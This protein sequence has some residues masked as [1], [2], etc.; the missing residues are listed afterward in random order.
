MV[1]RRIGYMVLHSHV[2]CELCY[3]KPWGQGT[4]IPY[5]MNEHRVLGLTKCSWGAKCA[6]IRNNF[7]D[8]QTRIRELLLDAQKSW[9]DIGNPRPTQHNRLKCLGDIVYSHEA[10]AKR[11][12]EKPGLSGDGLSVRAKIMDANKRFEKL[13]HD[14]GHKHQFEDTEMDPLEE[15]A[16]MAELSGHPGETSS[17]LSVLGG[18]G[19]PFS[20]NG[21]PTTTPSPRTP[22]PTPEMH[23]TSPYRFSARSDVVKT[24]LNER[25]AA[26]LLGYAAPRS[27]QSG[28]HALA[29]RKADGNMAGNS[30]R[31]CPRSCKT[32]GRD[33]TRNAEKYLLTY[34]GVC[35][36]S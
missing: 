21:Q 7:L 11:A 15:L 36:T 14:C 32:G 28:S 13:M 3:I 22:Q 8:I 30:R 25:R 27:C 20:F 29:L 19:S 31:A 17:T 5:E 34:C 12:L 16:K 2:S 18:V 35:Y 9:E 26:C 6:R 23:H 24:L 33:I 1:D 10:I 4:T